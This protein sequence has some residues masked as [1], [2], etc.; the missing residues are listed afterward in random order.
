MWAGLCFYRCLCE[1]R[2][3]GGWSV[4]VGYLT[5]WV[6]VYVGVESVCMSRLVGSVCVCGG[7]GGCG[8]GFVC[9]SAG[10]CYY[11]CVSDIESLCQCVWTL[12]LLLASPGQY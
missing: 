9:G 3:V 10:G 7:R 4:D 2:G 12:F 8:C 5:E 1:W 6:C 11:L